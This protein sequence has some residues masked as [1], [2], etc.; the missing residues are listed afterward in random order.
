MDERL[1][2]DH[3]ALY[4]AIQ[5]DWDYDRDV[6]F[7][8][9]AL[10]RHGVGG[11]SLLEVGCGTGEHTR[12]FVRRGFDV[13]ALDKY[14]GM[15]ERAREKCEADY[16]QQTLPDLAIDGDFDA[17][18]AIRGVINHLAPAE[19]DPAIEALAN[20]LASG[21]VLVFDTSPLPPDGNEP[22]L[23]VGAVGEDTYVRVARHVP[24]GT[25][26]LDWQ[27]VTFTAEKCFRN[28][29]EMTPF[30]EETVEA[31]LERQGL[32]VEIYDGYGA[33]DSRSVFVGTRS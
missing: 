27:S 10:D 14:E 4:D 8:L 7:V 6:E 30:S 5:A 28:S 9:E 29:R 18:V 22:A 19:L 13:T 32:S 17:V 23:D 1:Y 20:R 11:T 16:R 12:R 33:G 15:L 21:G 25:G 26:T 2:T 3:P 24:T 31:A